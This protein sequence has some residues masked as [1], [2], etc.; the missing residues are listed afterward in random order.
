ML[1][2]LKLSSPHSRVIH[3]TPSAGLYPLLAP[4]SAATQATHAFTHALRVEMA[5]QK[6]HV[7]AVRTTSPSPPAVPPLI[8][9]PSISL[10]CP[11]SPPL[12]PFLPSPSPPP[13][14]VLHRSARAWATPG[15]TRWAVKWRPLC[16]SDGPTWTR[17]PGPCMGPTTCT[18]PW[19][20]SACWPR[21]MGCDRGMCSRRC[22]MP[23]SHRAP[24]G[25]TPSGLTPRSVGD[26]S[27]NGGKKAGG[28]VREKGVERSMK[29][30]ID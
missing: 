5:P 30:G 17:A 13:P 12:T 6:L 10:P 4:L 20:P 14:V 19:T 22:T 1:P 21:R 8:P 27:M 7:C 26:R 28:K 25:S 11:F 29:G 2:L 23:S 16:S 3:V 18:R 24:G 9:F 15:A